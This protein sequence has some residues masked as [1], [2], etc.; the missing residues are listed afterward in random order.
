M[1]NYYCYITIINIFIYFMYYF[2]IIVYA[3]FLPRLLADKITDYRLFYT[4]IVHFSP[5]QLNFL[6]DISSNYTD[7]GI[8]IYEFSKE[9]H[10][11]NDK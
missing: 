1:P 9:F 7:S 2:V 8:F 6:G 4:N 11:F 3:P 5:S 10:Y